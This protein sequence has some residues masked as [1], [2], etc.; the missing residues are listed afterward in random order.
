VEVRDHSG[1]GNKGRYHFKVFRNQNQGKVEKICKK[2]NNTWISWIQWSILQTGLLDGY[3][4]P[5]V[6]PS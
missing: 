6:R 3:R 5:K 2:E 1:T 4:L